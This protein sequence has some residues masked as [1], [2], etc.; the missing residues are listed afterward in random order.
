MARDYRKIKTWQLTDELALMV[1]KATKDFLKSE[2]WEI[3]YLNVHRYE[4]LWARRVTNTARV[5]FLYR[6]V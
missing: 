6:K 2:I 1:Y 5:S 4:E 3:G